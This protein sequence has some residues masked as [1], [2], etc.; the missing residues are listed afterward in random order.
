MDTI[1]RTADSTSATVATVN[2]VTL[3][4]FGI[5]KGSASSVNSDVTG[6]RDNCSHSSMIGDA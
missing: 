1:F 6:K 4:F 2:I 3:D 5:G